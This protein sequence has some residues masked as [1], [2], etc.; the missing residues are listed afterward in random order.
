[1]AAQYNQQAQGQYYQTPQAVE[2]GHTMG[3]A[4]QHMG[5]NPAQQQQFANG[6]NYNPAGHGYA[7]Q[8]SGYTQ[9][10]PSA[11]ASSGVKRSACFALMAALFILLAAVIGLSAGLGVSQRNL[12]NTKA[13]LARATESPSAATTV[14]VTPRPTATGTSTSSS[15]SATPTPDTSNITC[16][17][18]NNTLYTAETNSSS[19]SKQFQQYCGIDFS[20]DQAVDVGSV[21]VTS[22]GACMDACASQ[23][24]C[25]G[26]GWGYLDGDNGTEHSCWMKANL[27]EPH[28]ATADWAFAV[29][30][31]GNG[32]A[33]PVSR[34]RSS[35]RRSSLWFWGA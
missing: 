18:S 23:S 13:D 17:G 30:L 14:F 29:L 34:R 31:N 35:S 28:N 25:T 8:A 21:K 7:P 2:K 12:R 20:G 33:D 10:P 11:P 1:M 9:P 4:P 5:Y 24:N 3:G 22:M 16:P 26:A 6:H 19:S 27:T 15:A 32:T